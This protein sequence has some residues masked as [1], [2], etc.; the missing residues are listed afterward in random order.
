[1]AS[2]EKL[3]KRWSLER[4]KEKDRAVDFKQRLVERGTPV[5]KRYNIK[6]V[7]LFGS[8]ASGRSREDSDIDLYVSA[9]PV[10]QYWRFRHELEEVVQLPIDLYTDSDDH[11]FVKKIIEC[12]EKVY[13][14]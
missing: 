7:Y 8:V 13:G 4:K 2:F 14:V 12:G 9:L 6:V 1:M 5:F 3:K 11:A 10:D